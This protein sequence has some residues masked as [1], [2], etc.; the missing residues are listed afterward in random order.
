MITAAAVVSRSRANQLRTCR[1]QQKQK[2][3]QPK[4]PL[5]RAENGQVV[6]RADKK[7][8]AE[9]SAAAALG[10]AKLRAIVLRNDQRTSAGAVA[11]TPAASTGLVNRIF[12]AN[13]RLASAVEPVRDCV[14]LRQIS[15]YP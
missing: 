4:V 1:N 13:R 6:E 7:R 11:A 3:E 14:H 9:V 15:K 10:A 2:A 8:A 12:A 5:E